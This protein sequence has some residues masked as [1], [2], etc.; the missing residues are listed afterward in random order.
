MSTCRLL[1]YAVADGAHN[2]AA[3]EALLD[4]AVSGAASLRFYGWTEP[5]LSLGYFQPSG[6]AS[7][8]GLPSG[9]PRVRRPSGG[10]ALLHHHELTYALALPAR[11]PR[12]P[13]PRASDWLGRVHAVI[14]TVLRRFDV[15]TD[16]YLDPLGI[17]QPGALCFRHFTTGD[18]M[19]GPAKVV[20]S[21][22]HRRRGALLQHG[23]ILLEQSPH[24]PT[25]PGIRE[26]VGL[27]VS[28]PALAEEIGCDLAAEIG[29][30]MVPSCW[31]EQEWTRIE[32]LTASK[33][34]QASWN[35]K[36]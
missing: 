11:P 21:A 9:L 13:F 15:I 19:I 30:E 27:S 4:A 16:A 34:L 10:A 20:G 26:L 18:L 35:A 36:R 2:M 28:G 3:D 1:P 12:Q 6:A 8:T 25:L 14:A 33:Y 5:T 24:T 23:A 7:G 32:E 29:F 22:Q 17:P 31:T